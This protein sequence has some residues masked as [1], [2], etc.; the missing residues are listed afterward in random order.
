MLDDTLFTYSENLKASQDSG[1]FSLTQNTNSAWPQKEIANTQKS[2]ELKKMDIDE[3]RKLIQRLRKI[4]EETKNQVILGLQPKSKLDAYNTQLEELTFETEK[5]KKEIDYLTNY[6][7]DI[8]DLE[9]QTKNLYSNTEKSNGNKAFLCPIDSGFVTSISK[10]D[11]EVALKSEE[12]LTIHKHKEVV[13]KAFFDQSDLKFI[14]QGRQVT[15][16]FPD[17]TTGKGVIK[18]IF[19]ATSKLPEEFQKKYES[20]TRSLTV[21]IVPISASEFSR[22]NYF[23]KM[24]VKIYVVK[25]SIL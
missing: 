2:I 12:I 9:L 21:D 10:K 13:I 19:S 14:R 16:E 15:V 23:Y 6:L 11:F 4:I 7:N 5:N 22:W 3:N 20:T 8:R 24:S 1:S 18:N 17:G 25:Y